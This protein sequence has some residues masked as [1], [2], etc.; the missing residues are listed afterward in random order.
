MGWVG[1]VGGGD[2]VEDVFLKG[3]GGKV[4][5]VDGVE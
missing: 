2:G 4:V 5:E 1:E 3:K